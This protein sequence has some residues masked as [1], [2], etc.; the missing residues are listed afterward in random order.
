MPRGA[1]AYYAIR[2]R[3]SL[4]NGSRLQFSQTNYDLNLFAFKAMALQLF[5]PSVILRIA[6]VETREI[7]C[8]KL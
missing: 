1:G 5:S 3:R 6:S 4:P 8:L 7:A 2:L